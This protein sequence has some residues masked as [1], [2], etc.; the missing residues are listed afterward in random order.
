M[1][2]ILTLLIFT[3]IVVIHEAGHMVVAKHFNVY[4]SEFAVGM[5]P[6]LWHLKKGVTDYSI[7]LLPLG[8]FCRMEEEVEE[9]SNLISFNDTTPIQRILICVA[10]PLMN[11]VLALI[12]MIVVSFCTPVSTTTIVNVLDGSPV[13]EVGL[14]AGDKVVSV[15][16]HGTHSYSEIEFFKNGGS[17]PD[18]ITVSRNGQKLT[19]N[20]TPALS[21][22][23]RYVYGMS[24]DI[25]RPY[26]NIF[27][28]DYTGFE[29]GNAFEY[30]A[31]GFWSVIF[32]IKATVI[33]FVKLF[34]AKLS[35]NQLSGPIGVTTEV[36][37]VYAENVSYGFK[38]VFLSMSS[39][40]VLLSANLGVLNLF[41]LPA[42]DGGRIVIAFVELVTRRRVS[43]N[44]EAFIHLVGF[45]LL[46]ALGVYVAFN[47]VLKLL[48]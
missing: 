27:H 29:K 32:Y 2:V 19:Y 3:V 40:T 33:S 45:V 15:N 9:N 13:A 47:D 4:V 23:N 8:G 43:K 14:K 34:T 36:G 26:F 37:N 18:E 38:A 10:G 20:I 39:L 11:F 16:G 44:I 28:N 42:L 41:P 48:L 6:R 7:R 31:G 12:L 46:M 5:G 25:K 1:S 21:K 17:T 30:I 24:L 35:V 22:D